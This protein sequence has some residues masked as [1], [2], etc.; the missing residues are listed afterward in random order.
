M[1]DRAGRK[2]IVEGSRSKLSKWHFGSQ[3]T[4]LDKKYN[5]VKEINKIGLRYSE[6]KDPADAEILLK[7]F[8]NFLLKYV[9]LLATGKVTSEGKGK[10]FYI[11]KDTKRFLALFCQNGIRSS[12]QELM[13]AA[14][15]L[16]NAFIS[17]TADDIYN[18]LVV[19]FLELLDNFNGTGGFT[20]YIHHRFAWSVKARVFKW[21]NDPINYQPMY[22][23]II[24]E[25]NEESS[26]LYNIIITP[27][28]EK[29][30][31]G[32]DLNEQTG[33]ITPRLYDIPELTHAFITQPTKPF[34][35]IWS[36][37]QRA[38]MVLKWKNELSNS[39]ISDQLNLGGAR[40]VKDLYEQAIIAF[41]EFAYTPEGEIE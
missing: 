41:K 33:E 7:S 16:P 30:Q 2:R 39:A 35:V 14:G 10:K 26:D 19:I 8:N 40:K 25:D 13:Q 9:N 17:M 12:R 5:K 20:G 31:V 34:D 23:D 1:K 36:K 22:N 37:E 28:G 18:E 29:A 11:S 27:N 24:E 3:N 6:K 21:Q 32:Y 4:N 15:R 38:I